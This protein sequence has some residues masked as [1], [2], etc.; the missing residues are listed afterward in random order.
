MTDTWII[1]KIKHYHLQ[2]WTKSELDAKFKDVPPELI[3]K[4]APNYGNDAMGSK[5][6]A[7][8]EK[9]SD[10]E[11][12]PPTYTDLSIS[13]QEIYNSLAIVKPI[14]LN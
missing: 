13:E 5:T 1:D 14:I 9:E 12:I 2:G 10:Y 8:F 3:M 11:Y 7:Y 4:L 6:E